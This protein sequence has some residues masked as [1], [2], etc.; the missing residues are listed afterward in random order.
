MQDDREQFGY[1]YSE[2]VHHLESRWCASTPRPGRAGIGQRQL[3]S[4]PAVEVCEV[5]LEPGHLPVLDLGFGCE[6]LSG[7]RVNS[8]SIEPETT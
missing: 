3:V 2:L 7:T 4:N 8:D 1:R 6:N 5:A